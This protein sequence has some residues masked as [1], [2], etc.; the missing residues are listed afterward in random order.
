VGLLLPAVHTVQKM[1]KE[2]K[3]RAQFTTIELGLAAFKNDF[4]DYPPSDPYSWSD[5]QSGQP[6]ENSSGAQK[7]TEAL[8]GWDLMGFHP[9]S[10]WRV[11]GTNRGAYRDSAG[12]THPPGQYLLYDR[13]NTVDM[14][15]RKG[16][17]IEVDTA[18]AFQLGVNYT[19]SKPYIQP[20]DGLFDLSRYGLYAAAVDSFVLCDV[21]G[22]G[23]E[24]S[25]PNGNRVKTGQ[26]ILYYRASAA[27]KAATEVYSYKDNDSLVAIKNDVDVTR[28]GQPRPGLPPWNPLAGAVNVFYSFIADPK[29]STPTF[30]V[31]HRPDSYLLISAGEDGFFGTKDD[32]CNFDH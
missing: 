3:Q 12:V 6:P 10:G 17:Y 21:F 14:Q 16:R 15:K 29:A 28:R 30:T 20:H 24:I 11:D 23:K 27:G 8:L 4:G 22:K 25:L 7:L 31:P 19:P 2:T 5:P 1:A 9:D 26:P 13:T 18:N 32:I